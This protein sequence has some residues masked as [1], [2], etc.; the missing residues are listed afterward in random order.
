[1]GLSAEGGVHVR[2]AEGWFSE[3]RA[4]AG[5]AFAKSRLRSPSSNAGEPLAPVLDTLFNWDAEAVT[6]ESGVALGWERIATPA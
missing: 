5:Y 6:L 3:F 4:E 1:M 2:L